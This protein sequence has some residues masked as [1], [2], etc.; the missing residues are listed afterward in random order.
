ML[1]KIPAFDNRRV[2]LDDLPVTRT[3]AAVVT[4]DA[5]GLKMGIDG[6]S[7]EKL[8]SALFQVFTDTVRQSVA[9]RNISIPVFVIQDGLSV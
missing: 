6:N 4:N 1:L 8:E 3:I 5:A 7:P 2:V 9:D